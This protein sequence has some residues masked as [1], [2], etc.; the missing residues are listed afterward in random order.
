M[1]EALK[2]LGKQLSGDLFVD[3]TMRTL[4][5]TDASAY[6]EMPLAVAIPK[7]TEDIKLLIR[8]AKIEKTSLIPRTAGTSLAGQVVGNGIIVDVSKYF[9]QIVE[10]NK[11]ENWVKVQPGV[12]RDELNMF[13]KPHGL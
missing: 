10:L 2:Q 13:L 12:I 5:A 1:K 8:F 9:T 3:K 6:R 11:E 4:Y 7:T